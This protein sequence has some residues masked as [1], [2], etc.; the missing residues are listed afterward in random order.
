MTK[1]K[2][3]FSWT[4]ISQVLGYS[5]QAIRNDGTNKHSELRNDL[6]TFEKEVIE[7]YSRKT[8]K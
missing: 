7:K 3:I 4:N 1:I 6:E 8:G 2:S 5:P